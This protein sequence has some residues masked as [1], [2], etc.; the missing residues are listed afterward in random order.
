MRRE[1]TSL[2]IDFLRAAKFY[3]FMVLP[4]PVRHVVFRGAQEDSPIDFSYLF[5]LKIGD[6]KATKA[7]DIQREGSKKA[8][9]TIELATTPG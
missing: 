4:F 8:A 2:I 7:A 6:K 1:E 3:F 9:K 5:F